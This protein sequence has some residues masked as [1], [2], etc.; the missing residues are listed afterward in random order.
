MAL[1]KEIWLETLVENFFP[2]NSFISKS[3]DDSQFVENKQVHI[4]NAGRPSAVKVNRTQKP[5]TVNERTD[6]EL[7]Y[8]LD[9][10][11]TDPVHIAHADTVEL[12][13][14]K[15]SS[16]LANDKEELQRVASELILQRWATGLTS[17]ETILTDGEDRQAH[18]EKG[19]GQRKKMTSQVVHRIALEFDRQDV[20]KIGRYLLLDADMYA[21]LLDSLTEPQRFAFLGTADVSKGTI[22]NLY[23]IDVFARSSVL[24]LKSDSSII[25][26]ATEGESTEVAAGLAWQQSSLS[27]S[28]GHVKMF[29]STDNPLY[30]GDIYSFLMRVGGS[31]RRYDKKGVL[32]IA[33]GAN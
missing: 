9:E 21:D 17:K 5:A 30:Y 23:G 3:I 4:P 14:D 26:E 27:R 25:P 11:T 28:L 10:L 20:P 22:G 18:T 24:R 7:T 6:N 2:D 15:R 13:Y 12:S 33:E 16:I 31:R 1:Q 29:D 8:N 19:T 32:L